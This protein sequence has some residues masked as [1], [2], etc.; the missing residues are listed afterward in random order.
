M[1]LNRGGEILSEDR[2]YLYYK[3]DPLKVTGVILNRLESDTN[4][5]ILKSPFADGN[6]YFDE[7]NPNINQNI[8]PIGDNMLYIVFKKSS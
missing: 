1:K 5:I 6:I 2:I 3:F 4:K 8:D 7:L